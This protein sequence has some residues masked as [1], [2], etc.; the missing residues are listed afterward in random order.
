MDYLQDYRYSGGDPLV[1]GDILNLQ[2]ATGVPTTPMEPTLWVY[3]QT[4]YHTWT[5]HPPLLE[6]TIGPTPLPYLN[7]FD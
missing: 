6:P 4:P 3:Q 2:V 1:T 5:N 7:T